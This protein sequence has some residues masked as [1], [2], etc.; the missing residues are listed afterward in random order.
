[1]KD[2]LKILQV[3]PLPPPVGGMAT[4]IEG[5]SQEQRLH[6]SVRILNNVKT[7]PEGRALWRGVLAQLHL[8][9][10]LGVLCLGWRPQVVHIHTCSWG[11]FWRNSVDVLL[12]RL[13]G[14]RV[15][16]HIHGAEFHK[17]LASLNPQRARMARRAFALTH[18]VI[19]LGDQWAEIIGPWCRPGTVHVVPNGVPVPE[20][21]ASG[22]ADGLPVILCMANYERRKGQVDLISALARMVQPARLLLH[23]FESES[24]QGA[25]LQ[26]HADELGVADRVAL[27]GPIMGEAKMAA[28][29]SADLFC[30]PSYDEGLPMSM[31]EAMAAGVAVVVTSVGAIPEALNTDEDGVIVPPGDVDALAD[32][33]DALLADSERRGR[34]AAT[35]RARVIRD[36]SV[37]RVARDLDAVYR[38]LLDT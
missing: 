1:M 11:T 10:R 26:A 3:G 27:P 36:Y 6:N 31:L 32:A 12:A 21:I 24:G 37:A 5:L 17:F 9:W 16:L 22:T 34:I 33:L 23:G 25:R 28:M 29:L 14:R 7:T 2:A 38:Q 13:L 18:E 20:Q 30:L 15:V 4:V 8:L 35:G 19:V